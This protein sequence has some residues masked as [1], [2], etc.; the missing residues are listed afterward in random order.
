MGPGQYCISW[1][2]SHKGEVDLLLDSKFE[3]LTV[4]GHNLANTWSLGDNIL[5]LFSKKVKLGLQYFVTIWELHQCWNSG[6]NFWSVCGIHVLRLP[7]LL[8]ALQ[9]G[10]SFWGGTSPNHNCK[11]IQG[12]IPPVDP[13][14]RGWSS[15]NNQNKNQNNHQNSHQNNHH[16]YRGLFHR[17]I[18]QSGVGGFAPS[19]HHHTAEQAAK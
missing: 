12:F 3:Q 1:R 7:P 2:G 9:V 18:L 19:F 5:W 11:Q 13:A 14:K 6:D 8:A 10:F 4:F 15:N 17:A 16:V